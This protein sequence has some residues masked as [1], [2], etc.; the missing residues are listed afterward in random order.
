PTGLSNVQ[1]ISAGEDHTCALTNDS[2]VV[3]WGYNSDGQA[4]HQLD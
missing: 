2:Q 3:C 1:A 4:P